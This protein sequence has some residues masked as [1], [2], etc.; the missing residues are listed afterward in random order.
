[1]TEERNNTKSHSASRS[2]GMNGLASRVRCAAF[3]CMAYLDADGQWRNYYTKEL[4]P[5]VLEVLA[6]EEK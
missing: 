6:P 2:Q 3:I 1:M 5:P 4:L